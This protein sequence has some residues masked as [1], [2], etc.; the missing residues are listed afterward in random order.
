[1]DMDAEQV[2]R[3]TETK[4]LPFILQLHCVVEENVDGELVTTHV[5]KGEVLVHKAVDTHSALRIK[6]KS[7]QL[8]KL[9]METALTN[10][11]LK[12]QLV[13][14]RADSGLV[15]ISGKG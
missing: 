7:A 10:A 1:M 13:G 2:K 14:E 5:M 9:A 11:G 15:V 8:A 6:R 4:K 12:E 3:I